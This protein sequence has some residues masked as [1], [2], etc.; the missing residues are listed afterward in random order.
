MLGKPDQKH[1]LGVD[2]LD[3]KIKK[4]NGLKV[5]KNERETIRIVSCNIHLLA[6]GLEG[7]EYLSKQ[8]LI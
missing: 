3:N 5:I 2:S 7:N 4:C 6:G 8:N 1:Q